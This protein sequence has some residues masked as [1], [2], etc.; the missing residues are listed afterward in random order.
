MLQMY[1][2]YL[3]NKGS[4]LVGGKKK[5]WGKNPQPYGPWCQE[6]CMSYK[7]GFQVDYSRR[8]HVSVFNTDFK[9]VCKNE[10]ME[11]IFKQSHSS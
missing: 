8:H 7:T 6:V 10:G 1:R 11:D 2:N 5:I 3:K 9:V 4:I